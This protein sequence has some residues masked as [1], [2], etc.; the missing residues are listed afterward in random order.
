[1]HHRLVHPNSACSSSRSRSCGSNEASTLVCTSTTVTGDCLAARL[2]K[3]IE[4]KSPSQYLTY[5]KASII[6]NVC[7]AGVRLSTVASLKSEA[8]LISSG[9]HN[10]NAGSTYKPAPLQLILTLPF[11]Q[12]VEK[13]KSKI[14]TS[15]LSLSMTY[16]YRGNSPAGSGR[17]RKL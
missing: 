15:S 12:I 6:G 3:G 8:F 7:L 2:S 17:W 14:P 10:P 16:P 13:I 1:M 4:I 9:A 5:L 11:S